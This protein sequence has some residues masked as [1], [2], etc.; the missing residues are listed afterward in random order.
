MEPLQQNPNLSEHTVVVVEDHDL[1]AKLLIEYLIKHFNLRVIGSV[2]TIEQAHKVIFEVTPSIVIVDV[3]LKN[4]GNG[5]DLAAEIRKQALPTKIII[6][7]GEDREYYI[8]QAI[9]VGVDA[10]ISKEC[11]LEDVAYAIQWALSPKNRGEFL[12]LPKTNIEAFNHSL[13]SKKYEQL[14]EAESKVVVQ[15]ARGKTTKEIAAELESAPTTIYTHQQNIKRKLEIHNQA[16][17]INTV[18]S[19][20]IWLSNR[21]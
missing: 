12:K 6:L 21:D 16:E 10:Y 13:I 2:S 20:T 7:T 3:H 5:I 15:M 4:H 11:Q 9:A 14:S 17:L 8:K 1:L 19:Y 18:L